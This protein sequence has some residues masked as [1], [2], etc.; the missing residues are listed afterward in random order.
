MVE[1]MNGLIPLGCAGLVVLAASP[2]LLGK[3]LWSVT[4]IPFCVLLAVP[5]DRSFAHTDIARGETFTPGH[6]A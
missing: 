3:R 6:T 2:L 5:R 1:L 4:A